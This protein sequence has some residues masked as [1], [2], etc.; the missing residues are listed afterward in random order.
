M[1]IP[2]LPAIRRHLFSPSHRSASR[3]S[4]RD[5]GPHA[6]PPRFFSVCVSGRARTAPLSQ[7]RFF[8]TRYAWYHTGFLGQR[9]IFGSAR[10][11]MTKVDYDQNDACGKLR[12]ILGS[13]S[14]R[15][16]VFLGRLLL[17]SVPQCTLSPANLLAAH[18]RLMVRNF[19][20]T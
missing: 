13:G 3:F 19:R 9:H 1:W 14:P 6:K 17:G 20:T 4:K 5:P 15:L 12:K 8:G 2:S 10:F 11:S 7:T 18:V 16:I